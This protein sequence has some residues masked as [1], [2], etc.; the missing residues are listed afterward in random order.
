MNAMLPSLQAHDLQR[1]LVDYLTTTFAL[2][3]QPAQVAL[4]DFLHHQTDGI[5]KGPFTRL[6][7]PFAPADTAWRTHLDWYPEDFTPYG[8][9]ARAYERLSS[10]GITELRQPQPTL[11]TTGTG[12]GKT[13]AF[14]HPILDHCLRARRLGITGMKALILY[15][16]NALASDQAQRIADAITTDERLSTLTAAIYTGESTTARTTVTKDGLITDRAIIRDTP[17]DI[18]LTNYKML[19]QLLLRPEDQNLWRASAD[20]L[21][22]LVLDEFHTYDGAQGTDVA[23][24]IRRLGLALMEHRSEP[25]RRSYLA[26]QASDNRDDRAPQASDNRDDRAPQASDNRDD[27]APQASDT[28]PLGNVIPVA[29]S[30]TL[31]DGADPATMLGFASTVFGTPFPPEAVITETRQTRDE[32]T[33]DITEGFD[34]PQPRTVGLPDADELVRR[35]TAREPEP[36]D[37]V[38]QVLA[39]L[40][41]DA[42]PDDDRHAIALLAHHPMVANLLDAAHEAA[43][44]DTL[45]D[46][47]FPRPDAG[48]IAT[49]FVTVLIAALSHLRTRLGRALPSV[50]VHLWVR[51]LT[52][53]DRY[54]GSAPAYRWSD[55]G[56]LDDPHATAFPAIYCRH[57]GRSGW[58]VTLEPT[59]WSLHPDD[60]AIRRKH[61]M[62]E[63]YFRAL[64]HAPTEAETGV[65][66]R[67]RWLDARTREIRG[68]APDADDEDYL[69]GLVLPVL[70]HG[71][72]DEEAAQQDECPSC[73][74]RDGIRFL[75][76][77]IATLLSVSLSALFGSDD[78]APADKKALVFTD[79]VQDAA[80]R[81]GFV[82]ARSH[83]LSLRSAIRDGFGDEASRRSFG[84]PQ[85]SVFGDPQPSFLGAAQPSFEEAYTPTAMNLEQLA[86]T[87]LRH[88][89]DPF[90]R[91]RLLGPDI[92]ERES[93][94]PFWRSRA[95]AP[96]WVQLN[97]RRRLL[98]DLELEFGL[99]SRFGRTLEATG[100]VV[101]EVDAR[102]AV[103]LRAATAAYNDVSALDGPPSD[104][105]LIAWTRGV[106]ERLRGSGA[107]QHEW[108]DKYLEEDGS[109]WRIWGG[110]PKKQG[111]P[112]FPPGRSAPTFPR[113]G[114][115]LNRSA[116]VLMDQVTATQGWYAGWAAKVLGVPRPAGATLS[117]LL[118]G[119]L[120]RAGV[121]RELPTR[122]GTAYA[123]PPAHVLV[124]PT[125]LDDLEA[126][127]HLLRCD[128]CHA[129]TAGT[130]TVI[131]QLAGAPCT[132]DRCPGRLRCAAGEDNYYRRLYG[133]TD[134]RR[135]VAREHSSM[136]DD[137]TRVGYENAFKA[138]SADPS[139]PNV[140]VATP[141]LE[142]GIDIGDLSTVMLASLPRT[143]ASY[144][145]RIGRAGR[146]TGNSLNLAYLT[147][148]G[149]TL[150]RLGD[151]LSV[152]NGE[153]RPPA[154]YLSAEEILQRQ[155]LASIVDRL[156]RRPGALSISKA[157]GVLGSADPGTWL[158]DLI[159]YADG[160]A[161]E[162][163][164]AFLA[165]FEGLQE[166]ARD[167]L[168]AWATP[169]NGVG[170]SGLAATAYA[171][172]GRWQRDREDL[173]FRIDAIQTELPDLQ[174]RAESPAASKADERAYSTALA[175]IKGTRKQ[176]ADTNTEYWIAALEAH[177]LLPNY[178]LLD[179]RVTLDVAISWIDPEDDGYKQDHTRLD[180]PSSRALEEFAPGATFYSRGFEIGIDAVDVGRD[181]ADVRTWAWCAECGYAQCLDEQPELAACPRCGGTA[182]TDANQRLRVVELTR[183]SAQLQRDEAHIGDRTDDRKRARFTVVP[184]VDVAPDDLAGS[185]F[186]EQLGF[187]ARY[188]R[189]LTIRWLNIGP[190]GPGPS[191]DL[192]GETYAAPLFRIC[193]GCGVRDRATHENRPEEHRPWCTHRN[194]TDEKHVETL[195]LSRTLHTQGVLLPLPWSVV[196]GDEFALPSLTAA[197]LLGLRETFGGSPDHIGVLACPDPVLGG[198]NRKAL[199]LHDTV[200]GG[201]GYLADLARPE[202]VWD[203]LTRA[204]LLVRDCAC[205][206]EG[207]QACHRCLLPF[208]GREPNKVSRATAE[209][210]LRD[211][212][213]LGE[214]DDPT[215]GM[216]WRVTKDTPPADDP[217]SHLEKRFHR[218]FRDLVEGLGGTIVTRPT[219][220]GN[221]LTITLGKSR[222][223]WYLSPQL[224][225]SGAKP[226]FVLE[227]SDQSI[228]RVAIFPDG[229]QWHA[230]HAHNRLAD[231]AEKRANLRDAGYVVLAVTAED[232]RL[233]QEGVT[234]NPPAWWDDQK[235]AYVVQHAPKSSVMMPAV[236]G[237]P[238][239]FLRSWLTDPDPDA[240]QALAQALGLMFLQSADAV[241]GDQP[242]VDQVRRRVRGGTS[243]VAAPRPGGMYAKGALG[244]GVAAIGPGPALELCVLLDDGAKALGAPGFEESWREWLRLSNA[245]QLSQAPLTIATLGMAT[246]V[247]VVAPPVEVAVEIEIPEPWRP[248]YDNAAGDDERTFLRAL[249][250]RGLPAPDEIGPELGEI[251]LIVDYAWTDLKVAV[252]EDPAEEDVTD[253]AA[254]GWR[255]IGLDPAAVAGVVQQQGR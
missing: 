212:L 217:W 180:R 126:A 137:K 163:L 35:L 134:M 3:D 37:L 160:H 184:A 56:T 92:V 123:I 199:L 138:A 166:T 151:P 21:T 176:L 12:S 50:E 30:A 71:R 62:N 196:L 25:S 213:T 233:H 206:D 216:L 241:D 122:T 11:V 104:D 169:A 48:D 13:E 22:Y 132:H 240:Q 88:A 115:P 208:A 112:A 39:V 140:L 60:T 41:D 105:T 202:Q 215:A 55:D 187:G 2:A 23:M 153:V 221:Q 120:A 147:G 87:V 121:L 177:G 113:V 182:L 250:D 198:E 84:A 33:A 159:E 17:P 20:S 203:L 226:D 86:D 93:F 73:G 254:E 230:S 18:L 149:D 211:L 125:Q 72:D 58:G 57:C 246:R 81:A 1:A 89:D 220:Q 26:P 136:L 7:L 188:A 142:M 54:A 6:R 14:T 252:M 189:R 165:G 231:D 66:D 219:A 222:R 118:L 237:G 207:R 179:D 243:V 67:L 111:M 29:T 251:G 47:V 45:A 248:A 175:A 110:R 146:R 34:L 40:Y 77:A 51:E 5:F 228:P 69:N 27:R 65:L 74:K 61:A 200:P 103:L 183:V 75:G 43:S 8:H 100:A 108:L 157:P 170:T 31:G 162:L 133:A 83:T 214:H 15:P 181:A 107:M 249:A 128:T 218:E 227:C 174:L 24:L 225:V 224:T 68:N 131:D 158:G 38:R 129:E 91:Y 236:L 63:P 70:T 145:Q 161:E 210:H 204:Y 171:A 245:L 139:A 44:L 234:P 10:K 82:E 4:T 96:N 135:V 114:P 19:D 197:I 127:R 124:Q 178:T 94:A 154:T 209:R 247:D 59:G 148:R 255:L 223:T 244:V 235:A 239:A 192:A 190:R 42:T 205:A 141:T 172:S 150:P 242:L 78:L 85:P 186:V 49:G 80:H 53:I 28:Y 143:V 164:S 106:L 173:Q 36:D 99:Q 167:A 253:L 46:T 101:A 130:V 116:E 191:R 97:V 64:I 109:R 102:P 9:Q 90:A 194:A 76:S 156:A 168:T 95:A 155:Y 232:V 193:R 201:T 195:A 117:K 79:S 238:F 152:I 98:F 52:R 16:M 144:L 185:W 32:W 229:R 119:Q